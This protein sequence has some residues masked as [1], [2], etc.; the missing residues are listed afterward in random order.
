MASFATL[1][2]VEVAG[3]R[4]LVRLDLNVP[5]KNGKVT[6]STRI[7]RQA[8]TVRELA[9]KGARVIVLS[10]FDRPGGKVV[11]EMSLQSIAPALSRA[12]A[13]PVG[14]A[15]ECIGPAAEAAVS[16]LHDGDVL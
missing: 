13:R 4:V 11:P 5:M 8:P 7:D 14:F 1:D 12:V 15:P 3:K 10:H 9:E 2:D 6:D 16:K